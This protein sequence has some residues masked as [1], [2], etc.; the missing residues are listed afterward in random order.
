MVKVDLAKIPVRRANELIREHGETGDNIEVVNPDA[1]HHIGVGLTAAVD[2]HV[3]G[4][5]GYFC[6][7]L[8]DQARFERRKSEQSGGARARRTSGELATSTIFS[9]DPG[10]I[11]TFCGRWRGHW[12]GN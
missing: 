1:R 10:L 12:R 2:V 11:G 8:T 5:A 7:G 3:R 9:M 4:S 6:A